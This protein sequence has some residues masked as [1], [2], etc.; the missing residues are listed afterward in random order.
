MKKEYLFNLLTVVVFFMAIQNAVAQKTNVSFSGTLT[1][2]TAGKVSLNSAGSDN[3]VFNSSQVD[4]DGKFNFSGDIPK[5]DVYK[6]LFES[7]NYITLILE[8]GDKID[9]MADMQDLLNT[10]SITGSKQSM[11]IYDGEKQLRR[12]KTEM[13]SINTIYG[14]LTKTGADDSVV[15]ILIAQYKGFEKQQSDYIITFINTNPG[16]L[17]CLFFIDRLPMEDNMNTYQTMDNSLYK[18]FPENAYVQAFHNKVQASMKLAVGGEAPEIALPDSTGKIIKLS[19]FRGKIVLI[20]FWASWCGPCRRELPNVVKMYKLFHPKGFE[21]YGV[22]LD[23]TR[24]SW[25]QAIASDGLTW[26]HVSDLKYWQCEAAKAYNVSGIPYTVLIDKEGKII[27]KG[28]RGA[29]LEK[30]LDEILK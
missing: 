8:P 24:E 27:A 15:K 21:I 23:K 17:A 1:N 9:I 26:T 11:L 7:G 22:S 16:S 20:D 12:Y 5:T 3:T 29:D 2:I 4:K 28:L 10:I 18:N 19:S 13:D 25:L 6:L 14:E 30:K